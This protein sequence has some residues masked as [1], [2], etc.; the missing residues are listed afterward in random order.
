MRVL[1][2]TRPGAKSMKQEKAMR[3]NIICSSVI[4]FFFEIVP[5]SHGDVIDTM[6]SFGSPFVSFSE[7]TVMLLVGS[8]LIGLA[9]F[10]RKKFKM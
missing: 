2:G 7:P 9:G 8:G 4:I 1:T 3:R 10:A 6:V 5:I